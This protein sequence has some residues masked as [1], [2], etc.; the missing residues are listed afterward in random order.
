MSKFQKRRHRERLRHVDSIVA[1]LDSALAKMGK[2]LPAV[3]RWKAEMP[4]EEEMLSK[5]KYT[6]F[7]RKEKRYRK[8]IHSMLLPLPLPLLWELRD[9]SRARNWLF[10]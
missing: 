6:M 1:T 4:T 2:T 3:E 8:G 7:D 9:R 10:G 5:D